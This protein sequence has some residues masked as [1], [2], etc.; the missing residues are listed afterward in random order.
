[1]T[2]PSI[3]AIDGPA[4]SGKTTLARKLAERLGYLYFDTGLMYRAVTLAAL[5]Q[6]MELADESEVS[7]LA[8]QIDIDVQRA[9]TPDHFTSIVFMNGFDVTSR[10]RTAEV[11]ANVSAV[12]AY[13]GVRDSMTRQQ[14]RIGERGNVVIVGRDIGTV[15]FPDADLKLYLDATVEERAR[16]R[17]Q[18][19]QNDGSQ[20]SYEHVLDAMRERDRKDSGRA[21]APML[22]AD[23]AI[24]IDTTDLAMT[25][26]IELVM[27]MINIHNGEETPA[28]EGQDGA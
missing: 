22:P 12:S 23:D 25:D 15:V 16:R 19:F 13:R 17:W 9:G 21:V 27:D 11:D 5:E 2:K 28:Q 26:L 10:L 24:R 4:A 7:N 6:G 18:D 20:H 3:I 14:R 1:M 8:Q